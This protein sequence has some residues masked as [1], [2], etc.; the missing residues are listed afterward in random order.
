MAKINSIGFS[1]RLLKVAHPVKK[2]VN[3]G[4]I[5]KPGFNNRVSD[6]VVESWVAIR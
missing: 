3:K 6:D 1:L 2:T 4:Q 5:N